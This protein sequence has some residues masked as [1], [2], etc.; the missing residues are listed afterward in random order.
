MRVPVTQWL[1][2]KTRRPF[3]QTKLQ[4]PG[5][6][7]IYVSMGCMSPMPAV[8]QKIGDNHIKGSDVIFSCSLSNLR[9]TAG[10][11]EDGE[12]ELSERSSVLEK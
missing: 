5:V 10:T 9:F 6:R 12:G 1:Q 2:Q 4:K 7:Y 3:C 11:G 8:V